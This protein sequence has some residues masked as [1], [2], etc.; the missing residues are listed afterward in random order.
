M[1]GKDRLSTRLGRE[2]VVTFQI[3]TV[4]RGSDMVPLQPMPG[5]DMRAVAVSYSPTI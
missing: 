2:G 3:R 4:S 5:Q 1:R